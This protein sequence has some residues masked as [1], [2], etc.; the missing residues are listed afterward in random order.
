MI[1]RLKKNYVLL[2]VIIAITALV[3][4]FVTYTIYYKEL[5][6]KRI[7]E[8]KSKA[9]EDLNISILGNSPS[10]EQIYHYAVIKKETIQE[11]ERKT[12]LSLADTAFLEQCTTKQCSAINVL[13]PY[14]IFKKSSYEKLGKTKE[15]LYKSMPKTFWDSLEFWFNY[16]KKEDTETSNIYE[17]YGYLVAESNCGKPERIKEIDFITKINK[18]DHNTLDP[19]TRTK[20]SSV[21]FKIIYKLFNI[22]LIDDI[23]KLKGKVC[24]FSGPEELIGKLTI[25][26]VYD[27]YQT[28][29]LCKKRTKLSQEDIKLLKETL[30]KNYLGLK[31]LFCQR[32]LFRILLADYLT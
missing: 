6:L 25:C 9:Y 2:F 28:L 26:E 15:E 7:I 27:Y 19:V 12:L 4:F 5:E 23:D 10:V 13:A 31:Q 18:F 17:L 24:L 3:S 30:N 21:K 29:L 20:V 1:Y 16:F 32:L 11:G 22:G 8:E 14:C